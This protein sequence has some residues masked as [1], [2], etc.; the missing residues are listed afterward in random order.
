M[1]LSEIHGKQWSFHFL[2][3]LHLVLPER[4]PKLEHADVGKSSVTD[5]LLR[6]IHDQRQGCIGDI[7]HI[8]N[9]ISVSRKLLQQ[10]FHQRLNIK[11]SSEITVLLET[12][13][14]SQ[15]KTKLLPPPKNI[16]SQTH[17]IKNKDH[18]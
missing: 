1:R 2:L 17:Q 12:K 14:L 5:H 7:I 11:P 9:N 6:A 3:A 4:V 13:S 8:D 16:A 15:W 18:N 10:S